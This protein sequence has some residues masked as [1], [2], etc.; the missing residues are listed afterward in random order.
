[1]LECIFMTLVSILSSG[2]AFTRTASVPMRSVPLPNDLGVQL[3]AIR[4][5]GRGS[6]SPQGL[7]VGRWGSET[8]DPRD[9]MF[10][11]ISAPPPIADWYYYSR[12]DFDGLWNS[13]AISQ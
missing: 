4:S 6:A 9:T 2:S 11:G 3:R 7:T 12:A 13:P 5:V 8:Q 1:M 10:G